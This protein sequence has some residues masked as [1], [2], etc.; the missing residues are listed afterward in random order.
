MYV[1]VNHKNEINTLD[2]QGVKCD[3][4][5][6]SML[7]QLYGHRTTVKPS[8]MCSPKLCEAQNFIRPF[9]PNDIFYLA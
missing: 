1:C 3:L 5:Q 8:E 6:D 9:V 4:I 7:D 2:L